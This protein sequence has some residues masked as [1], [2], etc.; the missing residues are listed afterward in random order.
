MRALAAAAGLLALASSTACARYSRDLE[1]ICA[2]RAAD[3]PAVQ[4]RTERGRKLHD[5][6]I[7]SSSKERFSTLGAELQRE[8]IEACPLLR[9]WSAQ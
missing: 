7:R 1:T 4:L 3:L 8:G 6:L 5:T 2:T 9:E